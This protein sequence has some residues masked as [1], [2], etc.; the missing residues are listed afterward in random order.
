VVKYESSFVRIHCTVVNTVILVL[1]LASTV[2]STRTILATRTRVLG[3]ATCSEYSSTRVGSTTTTVRVATSYSSSYSY[4]VLYSV[5]VAT[6][7]DSNC[8]RVQLVLVL[9]REKYKSSV[10]NNLA[11]ADFHVFGCV[12]VAKIA[13]S[14]CTKSTT[15]AS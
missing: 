1:V 6:T 12:Q 5:Q 9:E 3:V 4:Y 11:V 7:V 2:A 13:S 14:Y 8:T 15:V 10:L